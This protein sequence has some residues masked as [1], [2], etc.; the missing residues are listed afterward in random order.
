MA[1]NKELDKLIRKN[2]VLKDEIESLNVMLARKD[3]TIGHLYATLTDRNTTIDEDRAI[4]EKAL[5]IELERYNTWLAQAG[6]LCRDLIESLYVELDKDA[7]LKTEQLE[8]ESESKIR[9]LQERTWKLELE[10]E[11]NACPD[12]LKKVLSKLFCSN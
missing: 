1:K 2:G 6:K 12:R 7:L 11:E 10:I 3:T 9:Q 5:G 8:S 4:F